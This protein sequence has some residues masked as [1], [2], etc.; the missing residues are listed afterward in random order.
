MS[1]GAKLGGTV[2]VHAE[3]AD[4]EE[5]VKTLAGILAQAE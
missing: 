1:L 2:T 4:A 3:G 5:A